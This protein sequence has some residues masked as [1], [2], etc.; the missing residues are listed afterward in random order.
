MSNS[1]TGGN[2][3]ST[4]HS[5]SKAPPTGISEPPKDP[6][7]PEEYSGPNANDHIVCLH[8]N[9]PAPSQEFP[10][11][12]IYD[13]ATG[14]Q[15]P[16]ALVQICEQ[17]RSILLGLRLTPAQLKDI[18][19]A[20]F[21]LTYVRGNTVVGL[22]GTNALTYMIARTLTAPQQHPG[23]PIFIN[24]HIQ[25]HHTPEMAIQNL[26][27]FSAKPE[28]LNTQRGAPKQQAAPQAGSDDFPVYTRHES[29]D[30]FGN[31][32]QAPRHGTSSN[33][34]PDVNLNT[35]R[36]TSENVGGAPPVGTHVYRSSW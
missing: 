23:Q 33:L 1:H 3:S 35:S 18:I 34:F 30:T 5:A 26:P 29:T 17:L 22:I 14:Q 21:N 32:S 10:L 28:N 2:E 27:E 16:D 11:A 15:R 20:G 8:P 31:T 24:L 7:P 19:D 4:Q 12:F 6:D 36:S 9:F 13:Y 25:A